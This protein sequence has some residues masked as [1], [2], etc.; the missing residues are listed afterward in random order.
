MPPTPLSSRDR[1][2][3]HH[4]LTTNPDAS[5]ADI[6]RQIKRHPTTIMREVDA[7]GGRPKY[8]PAAADKYATFCRRCHRG[9]GHASRANPSLAAEMPGQEHSVRL[10]ISGATYPAKSLT[11]EGSEAAHNPVVCGRAEQRAIRHIFG[12]VSVPE[13]AHAGHTLRCSSERHGRAHIRMIVRRLCFVGFREQL[14]AEIDRW[15]IGR[16][17][18]PLDRLAAG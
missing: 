9:C 18:Q 6:G 4:A 3:I 17:H 1:D 12:R 5:W 10:Y 11:K 15:T 7:N 8:R 14:S 16:M 2:E 13:R